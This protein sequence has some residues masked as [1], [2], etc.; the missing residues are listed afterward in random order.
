LLKDL[1]SQEKRK[2]NLMKIIKLRNQWHQWINQWLE[3][4]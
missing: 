4:K 1:Q 2:S 3:K